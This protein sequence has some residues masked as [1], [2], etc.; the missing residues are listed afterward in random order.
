MSSWRQRV[1]V[2][3][4]RGRAIAAH[5]IRDFL[6]VVSVETEAANHAWLSLQQG[7]RVQNRAAGYA[8][9]RHPHGCNWA[10]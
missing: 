2:A 8:G 9:R 10:R 6:T 1:A 7:E 4:L 5:G 3:S